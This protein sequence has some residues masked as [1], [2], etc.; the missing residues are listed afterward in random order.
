[1]NNRGGNTIIGMVK[2]K[3]EVYFPPPDDCQSYHKRWV[4]ITISEFALKK[5]NSESFSLLTNVW[6]F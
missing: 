5:S 1:M 2:D 4:K 3:G 6:N